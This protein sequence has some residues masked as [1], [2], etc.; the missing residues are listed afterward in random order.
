MNGGK[1]MEKKMYKSKKE[2]MIG[3]VCGGIAEY[4][5]IDPTAIRL[6]FILFTLACGLGLLAYI[7][8][9]LIMPNEPKTM[10]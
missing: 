5:N 1:I 9:F 6:F 8:A 2:R 10:I 4:S 7:C 3:G